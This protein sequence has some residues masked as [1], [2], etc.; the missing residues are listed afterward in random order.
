M[1]ST[2]TTSHDSEVLQK[3]Y[4]VTYKKGVTKSAIIQQ[5]ILE[6]LENGLRDKPLTTMSKTTSQQ[7]DIAS[8]KEA[9]E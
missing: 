1:K 4:D 3:F 8:Q 9:I 2:L 5:L 6:Y 7:I